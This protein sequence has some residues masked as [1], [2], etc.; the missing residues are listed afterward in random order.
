MTEQAE[1]MVT[2]ELDGPIAVIGLNRPAKRNAVND[3]MIKQIHEAVAR[4]QE[5]ARVAVLFGHGPNFSAG[6]D[7]AEA[8]SWMGQGGRPRRRGHWHPTLDLVARG[9]IPFV[10]ALHGAVVGGGLE[11]AAAAHVRV[12]DESAFFALPEGQRGIFVGG[13]GSVRISRLMGVARMQDL[14]LT[15]RVLSAAE[16]ERANLCQYVVPAGG[17]FAKAKELAARIADN[18]PNS[19]WVICNGLPR[20]RDLSHNDGLFFEAL[21]GSQARNPETMD[22]L[23]A[24]VEHRAKG[25]AVPDE[26][27]GKPKSARKG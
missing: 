1:P 4:A 25:L 7:L 14:M 10:A 13:G 9:E 5:E 21:V 17:A 27:V 3:A 11:I 20:L 18:A 19:N 15:G 8:M 6:L 26:V 24:F 16:G 23:K 22:R 12:A 2:Y